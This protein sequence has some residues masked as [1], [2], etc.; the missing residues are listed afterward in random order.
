[1]FA[2][3]ET[4]STIAS[5]PQCFVEVEDLGFYRILPI[6]TYRELEDSSVAHPLSQQSFMSMIL[7]QA[8][9]KKIQTKAYSVIPVI[10]LNGIWRQRTEIFFGHPVWTT[11]TLL[12]D[13][14]GIRSK[15]LG[16][17]STDEGGKKVCQYNSAEVQLKVTDRGKAALVRAQELGLLRELDEIWQG[18]TILMEQQK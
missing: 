11:L 8:Q 1:M 16:I 7:R 17:Q 10:E 18:M 2:D 15:I 9:P 3:L 12:V 6:C 5:F 13:E 4:A 14:G